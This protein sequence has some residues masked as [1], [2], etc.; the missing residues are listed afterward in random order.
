MTTNDAIH[1]IFIATRKNIERVIS[2]IVPPREIEDIVQETYVRICQLDKKDDIRQPRAFLLKTARNLAIDYLKKA[3]VRLVDSADEQ[4]EL[5]DAS[6]NYEDD[7]LY[8]QAATNEEFSQF[9]EAVR[10]LPVQCRKVFVLKK[11]YGYSQQE[12]A[13]Q[14]NLSQSTVEKHIALGVKRCT[15]FMLQKD[16]PA[17]TQNTVKNNPQNKSQPTT[18]VAGHVGELRQ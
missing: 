2:R 3:E 15:L 14:L 5:L 10:L 17:A 8:Q 6:V 4:P 9:C 18:R 11:V 1:N 12:I 16:L 7:L 13:E